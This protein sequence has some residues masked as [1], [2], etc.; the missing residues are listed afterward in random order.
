MK[1]AFR[2]FW[3][4]C[5]LLLSLCRQADGQEGFICMPSQALHPLITGTG[6]RDC[7]VNQASLAYYRQVTAGI[8]YHSRFAMPELAVK[9]LFLTLPCKHGSFGFRYSDYGFSELKYHYFSIS[10][11]LSLSPRLAM[12]VDMALTTPIAPAMEY[13]RINA[14]GQAGMI[15]MIS[16]NTRIGL[17]ILNPVPGKTG[18]EHGEHG[19]R[20][21]IDNMVNND[22]QVTGLII[23]RNGLPLSLAAGFIYKV[24]Q[25]VG[26]RAGYETGN[27]SIGAAVTFAFAG[28]NAELAFQT[29]ER[30]GLSP[31]VA[32]S[33]T[34]GR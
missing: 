3:G 10:G 21:G 1:C 31:V 14:S 7:F 25:S 33:K 29:H 32:L 28:F 13:N 8:E 4:V 5:T 15:Y 34:F 22:L 6:F 23:K 2:L 11:G 26:I 27:S 20:L 17:H 16:G 18:K 9:S 24:S 12:G 19:V 30:L